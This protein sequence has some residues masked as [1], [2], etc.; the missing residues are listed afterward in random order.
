MSPSVENT[1]PSIHLSEIGQ[2]ALTV[3]DLAQ[4]KNFYQN[5]LGMQFL[6]EAGTMAFFQ[7]GPIRLMIGTSEKPITPEGTILYFRVP[8]IHHVHAAL[9]DQDVSILQE[10]H[11]VARTKSHDLWISFLKDPGNNTFALM[12][13]IPRPNHDDTTP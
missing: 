5:V 4:A 10:P 11:L 3:H 6:F 13:E 1:H 9:K 7:C 2:I 12:S 8:D